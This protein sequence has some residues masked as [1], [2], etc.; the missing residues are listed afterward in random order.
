M[1]RRIFSAVSISKC[2]RS[3]ASN[4]FSLF[5]LAKSPRIRLSATRQASIVTSAASFL[6]L[7]SLVSQRDHG[8]D[9]RRLPRRQEARNQTCRGEHQ[10]TYNE[11]R[12]VGRSHSKEQTG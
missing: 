10:G 11:G 12:D 8:I 6:G 3:S 7:D 2:A 1:P 9:S 5:L 4:S